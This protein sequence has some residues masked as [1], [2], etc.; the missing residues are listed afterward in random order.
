MILE[1]RGLRPMLAISIMDSSGTFARLHDK[2]E[3]FKKIIFPSSVP[4][5]AALQHM[6]PQI[7]RKPGGSTTEINNI[8]ACRILCRWCHVRTWMSR[9]PLNCG[10]QIFRPQTNKK[11]GRLPAPKRKS[12][13]LVDCRRR[14]PCLAHTLEESACRLFPFQLWPLPAVSRSPP[15]WSSKGASSVFRLRRL[16]IVN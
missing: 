13:K 10:G 16:P 1:I 9:L 15:S 8:S 14:D 7:S 2:N 5:E 3:Q 4:N 11:T 12:I 6:F